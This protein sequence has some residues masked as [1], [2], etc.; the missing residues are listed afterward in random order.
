MN[1]EKSL[2]LVY[3]VVSLTSDALPF[4]ILGLRTFFLQN[5]Q[6]IHNYCKTIFQLQKFIFFKWQSLGRVSD[7]RACYPMYF[8]LTLVPDLM[9]LIPDSNMDQNCPLP[10]YTTVSPLCSY[11]PA[12]WT[13]DS[14]P[15]SHMLP[16]FSIQVPR[17]FEME[18]SHVKLTIICM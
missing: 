3:R 13:A 12:D 10:R 14:R 1:K 11:R 4:V 6:F 7:I 8:V 5:W 18:Y 16:G 2:R 9:I 15:F 17:I